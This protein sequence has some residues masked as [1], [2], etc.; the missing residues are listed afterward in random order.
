MVTKLQPNETELIGN[1]SVEEANVR[2]D[3]TCNR[4]E[5]LVSNVLEKIAISKDWGAWET[6]FRDPADG[7]YWERTYPKGEMHGGGPP[8][9]KCLSQEGVK[10]KYGSEILEGEETKIY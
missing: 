2:A 1:W 4:I 9:L 8:A 7:R 10:L 3:E 6:L 5:W